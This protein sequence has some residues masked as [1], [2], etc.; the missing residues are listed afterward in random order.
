MHS[1]YLEASVSFLPFLAARKRISPRLLDAIRQTP[2]VA[3][4]A[5]QPVERRAAACCWCLLRALR[6]LAAQRPFVIFVLGPPCLGVVPFCI[7]AQTPLASRRSSFNDRGF[8]QPDR[9]IACR[10]S[11]S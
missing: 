9:E 8:D 7:R 6:A 4:A 10:N 5:A 1:E 3:K 11:G 2:C